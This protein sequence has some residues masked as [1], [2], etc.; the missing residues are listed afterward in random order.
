MSPL[1]D[2]DQGSAWSRRQVMVVDE[3]LERCHR[4]HDLLT[5]HGLTVHVARTAHQALA[6]CCA[7]PPDLLIAST[8]LTDSTAEELLRRLD[9]HQASV[10]AILLGH[11]AGA[12]GCCGVYL[13]P[14]ASDEQLLRQIDL[15]LAAGRPAAAAPLP[16]LLVD[17][18]PRVA[19][20]IRDYLGIHGFVVRITPSGEEALAALDEGPPLAIVLDLLLPGLDGFATLKLIRARHPSVPVIIASQ[21]DDEEK[22]QEAA[23]LGANEYLIKPLDFQHLSAIL[24]GLLQPGAGPDAPVST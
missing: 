23:E 2:V 16:V 18:E 22:R 19:K 8:R 24:V 11:A 20:L 15:Q 12:P 14:D 6:A 13:A 3:D 9:E 21:L 1:P 7:H 4:L 10:P 17:D 5:R